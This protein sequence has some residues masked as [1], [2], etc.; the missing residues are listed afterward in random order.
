MELVKLLL[1]K[2][3]LDGTFINLCKII[4]KM[5]ERFSCLKNLST[6]EKLLNS[7]IINISEYLITNLDEIV[8]LIMSF[9]L[10]LIEEVLVFPINLYKIY[11]FYRDQ[12]NPERKYIQVKIK[13]KTLKF[14]KL[15][16][17]LS[18]IYKFRFRQHKINLRSRHF[19]LH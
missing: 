9:D 13:N 7:I 17:V 11:N 19:H 16:K 3:L 10:K 14:F 4:N 1:D 2:K 5:V 12:N 6:I 15:N 18:K 8:N